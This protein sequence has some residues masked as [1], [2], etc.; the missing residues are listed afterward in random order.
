MVVSHDDLDRLADDIYK[1]RRISGWIYC[2]N[3][4]YNLRTLPYV[5]TCPEC[6]HEYNARPLTMRGIFLPHEASFPLRDLAALLACVLGTVVFAVAH[7]AEKPRLMIQTS[8]DRISYH[9][10]SGLKQC[11]IG[12]DESNDLTIVDD[13]I[14][15]FHAS[16]EKSGDGYS[17]QEL[18]SAN[19][20][21]VNGAFIGSEPTPL[22]DT[23]EI[24][25]GGARLTYQV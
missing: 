9:S 22:E 24:Q 21:I 8:A 5:Y 25:L 11:R 15:R 23:D 19:G 13:L 6:G 3:C 4:G 14:S 2:G 20:V 16:I 17:I 18:N 7:S 1:N 12:R 10:L